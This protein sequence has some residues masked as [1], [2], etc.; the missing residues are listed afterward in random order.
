MAKGTATQ[1]FV[2]IERVRDGVVILKSGELRAILITNSLNLALKSEDE[3]QAIL[4]QFQAFLNSLDFDIQFFIESRRLNIKPYI[5]LLQ[6][7]SKEVKEDLLKIQI[8]EYIAFITKFTEES[9]IMTKH[10]FITIPYFQ[11]MN[12]G[13]N[14]SLLSSF[15]SSDS[16]STESQRMFEASRIQL[17]QRVSTV[18]QGLSRFGLRAQKLGTEEV[19]ELFYKLFNPSEQNRT[20]PKMEQS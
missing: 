6:V 4:V 9:N 18:V 5:D 8:H 14:N 17:E 15:T 19:V 13:N 3:Q 11:S 7:R 1:E 20:A 12:S 16:T 10:F 2:P